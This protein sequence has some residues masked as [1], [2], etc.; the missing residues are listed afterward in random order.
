[1]ARSPWLIRS[2]LSPLEILPIAQETK[3]LSFFGECF[4]LI[5]KMYVVW[6]H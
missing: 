3:Y 4:Y 1:M 5:M 6:P 2:I